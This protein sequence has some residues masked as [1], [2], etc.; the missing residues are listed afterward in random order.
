MMSDGFRVD[1]AALEKA[2]AGINMTLEDLTLAKIDGLDG[3]SSA[4]GH[5][6]LSSTVADFCERWEIGVEHLAVD[7]Q[8]VAERLSQSAQD[9]RKADTAAADRLNGIL[10][11]TTGPDPA[12]R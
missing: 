2:S 4:Y 3:Q 11:R 6:H 1:L 10:Q 9:Y 7:G 12:A 5:D 8:E